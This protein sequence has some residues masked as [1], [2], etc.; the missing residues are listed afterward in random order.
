MK[1]KNSIILLLIFPVVLFSQ[2]PRMPHVEMY[3]SETGKPVTA[4]SPIVEKKY[5]LPMQR[6]NHSEKLILDLPV[7]KNLGVRA[8]LP[9][10]FSL[11]KLSE[12]QMLSINDNLQ[13]SVF[14]PLNFDS[15]FSGLSYMFCDSV[16]YGIRIQVNEGLQRVRKEQI[17]KEL[18]KYFTVPDFSNERMIVYSDEDFLVRYFLQENKIE[19]FSLFHYPVVESNAPG[20]KQKVYFGPQWYEFPEGE[21]IMLAFFNQET[22]ENNVQLAA[23]LYFRGKELIGFNELR[24]KLEN[25]LVINYSLQQ[26]FVEKEKGIKTERDTRI[27]MHYEQL[28]KMMQSRV[29]EVEVVGTNKKLSYKMPAFQKYSLYIAYQYYRWQATNPMVKYRGI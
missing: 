28:K 5:C 1:K 26:E 10:G 24:F 16:V 15:V 20:I 25:G 2:Q 9:F 6:Y 29:V 23:K 7:F 13:E 8:I 27:Y 12:I 11:N 22:K 17:I 3:L 14:R 21:A 4:I 19:A 18:D